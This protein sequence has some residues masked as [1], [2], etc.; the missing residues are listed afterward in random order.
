MRYSEHVRLSLLGE[1]RGQR[2]AKLV[3]PV[4][5][6]DSATM[7]VAEVGGVNVHAAVAVDGRDRRQLERLCR[8]LARPPLSQ[9]RLQLYHDGRVRYSFK[10]AWKDGTHAVLLEPLDFISR[11]CALIPP[12]R[13]HM[14]S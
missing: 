2:T 4:R 13:F 9:E 7:P 10:K 6:V 3:H 11:L 12:P 14:L 1:H 8:Y 5:N